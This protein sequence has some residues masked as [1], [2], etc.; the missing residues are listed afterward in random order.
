[1]T[2][3][4]ANQMLVAAEKRGY[5]KYHSGIVSFE[6]NGKATNYGINIDGDGRDGRLFGCPK[7]L[8]TVESVNKL[9]STNYKLPKSE[10]G[11][12]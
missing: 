7:I 8:W 12:R 11:W 4:K 2:Y 5:V 3:S 9:L 10:M 1:M 6:E